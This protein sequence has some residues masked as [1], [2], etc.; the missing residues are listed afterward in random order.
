MAGANDP[1]VQSVRQ[2]YDYYK[3]FGIDDRG[4]G[5]ELPQHGPDRSRWPGATC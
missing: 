1:G 5:R 2:I 3:N 4:H